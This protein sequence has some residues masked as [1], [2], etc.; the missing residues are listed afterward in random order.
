MFDVIDP[1]TMRLEG[2][3]PASQLTALR[4]GVPVSFTV[5]GYPGREYVGR[6]T[7]ISPVADPTTRQVGIFVSIPN[8][9]QTLVGGLFAEGRVAAETRVAALAPASALDQRGIKPSA[10]RVKNGV[11]ERVEV[12]LGIHDALAERYEIVSGLQQGDTLLLG[13][14][15]GIAAGTKVV[16]GTARDGAAATH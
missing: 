10:V 4:V 9:G 3:V 5:S 6:I 1:S 8:A 13:P 2:S 7:R 15:Q 12:T 11:V 14:A 16:V